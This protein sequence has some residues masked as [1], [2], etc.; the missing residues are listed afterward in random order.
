MHMKAFGRLGL[1]SFLMA[2]TFACA[3]L[4][5]DPGVPERVAVNDPRVYSDQKPGSVLIYNYYTSNPV[6]GLRNTE[7][8]F[9]NTHPQ[10]SAKVR[11]FF[12]SFDCAVADSFICLTAN[13][14]A[15]FLISNVDPGVSGYIVAYAVEPDSGCP[16]SF[17]YLIGSASVKLESGH[18]ANLNALSV[19]ALY[20]GKLPGCQSSSRVATLSFDGR[21]YNQLPQVLAIDKLRSPADGNETLLIVNSLNGD[22]ALGAQGVGDLDGELFNEAGRSFSF[23]RSCFCGFA[24]R[25]NEEFPQTM[26]TL[27]SVI[28]ASRTGWMKLQARRGWALGGASISFNAKQADHDTVFN[29]GHN[30]HHLELTTTSLQV[31]VFPGNC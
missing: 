14:T 13:Q 30:L 10:R 24:A 15:T 11:I 12:I 26:P 2:C 18:T 6:G 27:G 21:S 9:T 23:T 1:A 19:A 29:G 20:Q 5:A 8:T 22:L 28:P 16:T 31:P 25:L 4:A 3:T 7:I 17:N